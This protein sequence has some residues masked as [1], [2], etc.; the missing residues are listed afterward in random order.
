MS[1]DWRGAS[2]EEVQFET[3]PKHAGTEGDGRWTMAWQLSPS[4]PAAGAT[5]TLSSTHAYISKLK[6]DLSVK[7]QRSSI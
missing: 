3:K 7:A 1:D 6:G 2:G 5:L 4:L